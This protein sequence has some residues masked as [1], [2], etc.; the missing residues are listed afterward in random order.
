MQRLRDCWEGLQDGTILRDQRHLKL[1]R[2]S[3][4]LTVVGA[5]A[6]DADQ[7]KNLLRGHRLFMRRQQ[8]FCFVHESQ[9]RSEI[10]Q[11]PPD[12]LRQNIAELTAP[13]GWY[14]PLAIMP[15]QGFCQLCLRA[16]QQQV[17]HHVGVDND[18]GRPSRL[19]ASISS[20]SKMWGPRLSR[21][22]RISASSSSTD[23]EGAPRPASRQ[24]IASLLRLRRCRLA[25]AAS[26]ACRASGKF[27]RVRVLAMPISAR[28]RMQPLWILLGGK[29]RACHFDAS[30]QLQEVR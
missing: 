15:P 30:R 25:A 12:V 20:G 7:M 4:E 27:L 2:C 13:E 5:A 23:G 28:E 18:Q 10:Q 22:A 6:A 21:R 8:T 9:C 11:I 19:K 26:R 14:S 3:H 29:L 1:M 17:G 16:G 24:T